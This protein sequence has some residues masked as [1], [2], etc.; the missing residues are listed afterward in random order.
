MSHA[1]YGLLTGERPISLSYLPWSSPYRGAPTAACKRRPFATSSAGDTFPS[2]CL[3]P[4]AAHWKR[5]LL[6][7]LWFPLQRKEEM[8]HTGTGCWAEHTAHC[9][10]KPR[11]VPQ[12]PTLLN[13]QKHP[14][15]NTRYLSIRAELGTPQIIL[16]SQH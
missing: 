6:K 2:S 12:S 8:A 13:S 7:S 1:F 4:G 9:A 15:P 14:L 5:N 16:L 10:C 3:L 11:L